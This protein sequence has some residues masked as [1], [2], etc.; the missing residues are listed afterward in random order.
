MTYSL[1]LSF[2][3]FPLFLP[4]SIRFL[5]LL[6]C[7]LFYFLPYPTFISRYFSFFSFF[8]FG[9]VFVSPLLSSSH[10]INHT[11]APSIVRTNPRARTH[12]CN[13]SEETAVS[14]FKTMPFSWELKRLGRGKHPR[15]LKLLSGTFF[16]LPSAGQKRQVVK[17]EGLNSRTDGTI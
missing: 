7:L 8:L 12:F 6:L 15:A 4:R 5:A 11:P 10:Y 1:N 9:S 17:P 16:S 3:S 13:T 2:L 14:S